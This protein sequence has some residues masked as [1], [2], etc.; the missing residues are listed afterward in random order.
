[1]PRGVP[2]VTLGTAAALPTKRGTSAPYTARFVAARHYALVKIV[3]RKLTFT[4]YSDSGKQLD[5]FEIYL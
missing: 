4:V 1:H 3:D 2:Y 5:K